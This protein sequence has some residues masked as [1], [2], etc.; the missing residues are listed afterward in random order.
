[1]PTIGDVTSI[2]PSR[3]TRLAAGFAASAGAGCTASCRAG[4]GSEAGAALTA[5]AAGG[6]A[7]AAV[8]TQF[9]LHVTCTQ[10][11]FAEV[12]R[13]LDEFDELKHVLEVE[14]SVA[15]GTSLCLGRN[16]AAADQIS[17]NEINN[18]SEEILAQ[19]KARTQ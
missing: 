4:A 13:S 6:V 5:G 11:N 18:P 9:D 1:V 17:I 15:H 10:A 12:G 2:V 19:R 14:L 8:P 3:G 7:N 16:Q